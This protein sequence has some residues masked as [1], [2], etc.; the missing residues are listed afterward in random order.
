MALWLVI[1]LMMIML[2]NLFNQQNLSET[3][4]SYTDFLSMVNEDRVA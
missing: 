4:V 3:T 2:Y 1:T